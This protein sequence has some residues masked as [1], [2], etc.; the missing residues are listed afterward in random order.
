MLIVPIGKSAA[1]SKF[2]PSVMSAVT[3]YWPG[4]TGALPSSVPYLTVIRLPLLF[5]PLFQT[6]VTVTALPRYINS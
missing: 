1:A 6:A 3:L 5:I 2:A 4:S